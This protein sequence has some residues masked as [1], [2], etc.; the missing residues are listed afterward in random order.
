M[1]YVGFGFSFGTIINTL[2]KKKTKTKN[3][4][5]KCYIEGLIILFVRFLD[6]N[7]YIHN[8]MSTYLIYHMENSQLLKFLLNR[9]INNSWL[10]LNVF[11]LHPVPE[12]VWDIKTL[13]ISQHLGAPDWL[14]Q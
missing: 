7:E 1:E 12:R 3:I 5:L 10:V 2:Q 8:N 14:S 13:K 6:W 4:A 9:N 11:L